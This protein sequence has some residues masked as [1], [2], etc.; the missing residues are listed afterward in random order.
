MPV[1]QLKVTADGEVVV[2]MDSLVGTNENSKNFTRFIVIIKL[3]NC[4]SLNKQVYLML[5]MLWQTQKLLKN[6]DLIIR[7]ITKSAITVNSGVLKVN[8][9]N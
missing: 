2:D 9:S 3:F 7:R 8:L 5:E 1:P 6:V 4:R